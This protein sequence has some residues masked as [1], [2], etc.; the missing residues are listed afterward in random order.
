[1]VDPN[2]VNPVF[3]SPITSTNSGSAG[4][5]IGTSADQ[6]AL[7]L[8]DESSLTKTLIRAEPRTKAE[9]QLDVVFG[10]SRLVDGVVI[11]GQRPSEW[12]VIGEANDVSTFVDRIDRE[13]HV[14]LV[15]HTHS[16]AMMRLT[17]LDASRVLEKVCSLDWS[18]EMTPNGAVV[19]A[20]VAK[21]G[22]DIV[23][24]DT[25]RHGSALASSAPTEV[26]PPSYWIACDRSFAQYLFDAILDAG[27]EFGLLPA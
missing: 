18:S 12:L 17:G 22:C 26:I 3:E 4:T 14:S 19:S 11:S 15:D 13:G 16:R 6:A 10:A 20:S 25:F 21:V 9:R 8:A 23:R 2:S 5:S 27:Q 7:T 1:M 24:N